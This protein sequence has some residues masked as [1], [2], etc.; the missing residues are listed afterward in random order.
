MLY[1][2]RFDRKKQALTEEERKHLISKTSCH[3]SA[4]CENSSN[5]YFKGEVQVL[6][7]YSKFRNPKK[8]INLG[9]DIPLEVEGDQNLH[10]LMVASQ[11][12]KRFLMQQHPDH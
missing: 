10:I 5:S 3:D 7:N 11:S 2:F 12:Q 8:V 9:F 1:D 6:S 4:V